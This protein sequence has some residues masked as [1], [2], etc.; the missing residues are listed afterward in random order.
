M[1][2]SLSKENP[3]LTYKPDFLLPQFTCNGRKVFLEPHGIK[4]NLMNFLAKLAFFH[5]HYCDYFCLIKIVPDDFTK[6][7]DEYDPRY[8]VYD[9]LWKQSNYKTQFENFRSS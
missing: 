1:D 7:I 2:F 4:A 8:T 6:K 9:F 5:K 3:S